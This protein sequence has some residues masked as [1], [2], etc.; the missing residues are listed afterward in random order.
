[1]PD[2]VTAGRDLLLSV[3]IQ[4]VSGTTD[5]GYTGTATFSSDDP[6]ALLPED[7]MFTLGFSTITLS[8]GL[9]GTATVDA[10]DTVRANITGSLTM[11]V[12]DNPGVTTHFGIAGPATV[13]AGAD[14]VIT[15]SAL[16]AGNNVCTGYAGTVIFATTDTAGILPA[17][18]TLTS[19]VRT[20]TATLKT[21]GSQTITGHDIPGHTGTSGAIMV[22]SGAITHYTIVTPATTTA[23][24]ALNATVTALDV[25]NNTATSYAGTVIFT[26]S[27]TSAVLPANSTLTNGVGVFA[28]TLKQI[29]AH[30]LT[31][32]DSM[33][34]SITTTVTPNLVAAPV[35]TY[36]FTG[37]GATV[38][39][40][41]A[42]NIVVQPRDAFGNIQVN[43]SGVLSWAGTDGLG[44]Y[45]PA[46]TWVGS[47]ASWHATLNTTGTQTITATDTIAGIS[48]QSSNIVVT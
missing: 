46:A 19:G 39:A 22:A 5:P 1:M 35:S 40:G 4:D 10:T 14:C 29:A 36:T 12:L 48:K 23:G 20:L 2:T 37:I 41:Q 30:S 7:A 16:D 9:T 11:V 44:I 8:F 25:L 32:K 47:G 6:Y 42:I 27:G 31:V 26:S 17:N 38:T 28:V 24:M 33:T 13:T 15:V 34:V 45:P 43:Y 21:S 18:S 3:R